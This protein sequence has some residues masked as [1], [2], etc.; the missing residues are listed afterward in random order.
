MFEGFRASG[1]PAQMNKLLLLG[2]VSGSF[3][4]HL[5]LSFIIDLIHVAI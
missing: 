1:F 3:Y 5:P 4:T 2:K